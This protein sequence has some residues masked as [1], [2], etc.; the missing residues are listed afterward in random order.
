MKPQYIIKD[1][2]GNKP[3]GEKTF[4]DFEDAWSHVYS[5]VDR[6]YGIPQNED[7]E[8]HIDEIINEYHVE[9]K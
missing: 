1:W 7:Q 9:E 4:S 2:V 3:F 5:F 8:K 6:R